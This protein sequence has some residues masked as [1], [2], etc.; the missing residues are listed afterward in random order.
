MAAPGLQRAL[1]NGRATGFDDALANRQ[2]FEQVA[3][4]VKTAVDVGLPERLER[5]GR[6]FGN[7]RAVADPE[8]DPG[9]HTQLETRLIRQDDAQRSVNT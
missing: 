5:R 9:R 7:Q 4:D 2:R 3:V 6:Q 8:R 1:G